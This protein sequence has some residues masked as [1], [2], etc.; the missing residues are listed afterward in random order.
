MSPRAQG[1][2]KTHCR[3]TGRVPTFARVLLMC[4]RHAIAQSHPPP[5]HDHGH[6]WRELVLLGGNDLN[7]NFG[8]NFRP[9]NGLAVLLLFYEVYSRNLPASRSGPGPGTKLV[10]QCYHF[11]RL[12]FMQCPYTTLMC[13]CYPHPH[14]LPEFECQSVF[15]IGRLFCRETRPC[16]TFA[17]PSK[18]W[19]WMIILVLP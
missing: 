1:T 18:A 2:S 11:P 5:R 7:W 4:L 9:D 8:E 12:S 17:S 19:L 13:M 14:L 6:W 16:V 10:G 3:S 15:S